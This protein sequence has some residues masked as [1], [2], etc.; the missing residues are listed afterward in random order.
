ME[1]RP[2]DNSGTFPYNLGKGCPY[3]GN[4]TWDEG[5]S[6]GACVN[7]TCLGCGSRWNLLVLNL[8]A[9]EISPPTKKPAMRKIDEQLQD[10]RQN[11]DP[12][13]NPSFPYT[14]EWD[15]LAEKWPEETGRLDNY[16]VQWSEDREDAPSLVRCKC[17][18]KKLTAARRFAQRT[19]LKET[20]SA[21]ITW[22]MHEDDTVDVWT[23]GF[24][25]P[26]HHWSKE[27]APPHQP[28]HVQ[29]KNI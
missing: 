22:V 1:K 23:Q 10:L 12:R 13:T 17:D 15:H 21:N 11:D 16:T 14:E 7:V 19:S 8:T 4:L 29:E 6:G 26:N 24:R 2:P 5:P 25:L 28:S 27:G 3:C 18:F 20:T 9:H